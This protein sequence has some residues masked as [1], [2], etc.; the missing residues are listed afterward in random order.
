MMDLKALL[1]RRMVGKLHR[2]R[3]VRRWT[4]RCHWAGCWA[5]QV[6]AE[7]GEG[8]EEFAFAFQDLDDGMPA[9]VVEVTIQSET[10][11]VFWNR[12]AR[13]AMAFQ[14]SSSSSVQNGKIVDDQT[15]S[16]W[17]VA[18]RAVEG[19]RQ[20]EHLDPVKGA[21]IAS[22]RAWFDFQPDSELW[23]DSQ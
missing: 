22:G 19:T 20:G 4:T 13:A 16:V 18:G 15:Q 2:A 7:L 23:N 11:T 5:F 14:T 6:G 12:D 8:L 3:L 17:T 1:P 21:Y 10:V 9:R